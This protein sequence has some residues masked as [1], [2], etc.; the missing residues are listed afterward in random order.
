METK[1]TTRSG[2]RYL[3]EDERLTRISEIPPSSRHVGDPHVTEPIYQR[4]IVYISPLEVGQGMTVTFLHLDE[5]PGTLR[6]TAIT[7]I[8]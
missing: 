7:E 5:T 3:I 6:T 8:Q 1:V 4:P 2:A